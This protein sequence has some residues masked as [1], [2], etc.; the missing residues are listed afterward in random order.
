MRWF[1]LLS[2]LFYASFR[3]KLKI[4]EESLMTFRVWLTDVDISFM[5]NASMMTVMEMGRIDLMVRIGFFSLAQKNKW[6]FPSRG[7]T[8]QFLRPLKL[9]QKATLITRIFYVDDKWIYLEQKIRRF[10][11]DIAFCIVKCTVKKGIA[12]IDTKQ[13]SKQLHFENLPK[14]G[15]QVI[16]AYEQE[17]MLIYSRLSR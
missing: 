7:I 2:A 5:N 16:D 8:V 11:K 17:N 12:T 9:F 3:S 1:R 4:R 10:E 13:I 6:Y 15:K 14:E